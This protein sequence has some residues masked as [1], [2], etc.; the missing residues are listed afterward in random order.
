MILLIDELD[1]IARHRNESHET[2]ARM[3]SILLAEL[4]GLA[5][6]SQVLLV[7]SANDVTALDRAVVDRFD[8]KIEFQPPDRSQLTAA[9]AYYA[10]QLSS[11]DVAEL[12]ERLDGWNFRQ[13]A[14]FAEDVV[15]VYV[16]SLDL[17]LLESGEPPLP[18]KQDYLA[19]LGA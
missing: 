5:E 14:R 10:R 19:A 7:G 18:G 16:S 6:A 11:S 15:R 12:V 3:V 13:I 4:D 2:T 8:L 17:T 9:L 1:A